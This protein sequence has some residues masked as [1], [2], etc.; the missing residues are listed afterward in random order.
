MLDDVAC[1]SDKELVTPA[2]VH[3]KVNVE[4]REDKLTKPL[5]M[6]LNLMICL[7]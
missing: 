7:F 2:K 5:T 6:L 4:G 1:Y 3:T